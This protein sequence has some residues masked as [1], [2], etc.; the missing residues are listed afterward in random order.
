MPGED[1]SNEKAQF[2][3]VE[4]KNTGDLVFDHFKLQLFLGGLCNATAIFAS[5]DEF[6]RFK[7]LHEQFGVQH[8]P[9]ENL[10]RS[11]VPR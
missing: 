2:Y 5:V 6:Q 7:N 4:W 10:H 9:F 1:Q 11:I 3:E 8:D